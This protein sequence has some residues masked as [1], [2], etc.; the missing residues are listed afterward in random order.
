MRAN[1]KTHL[2]GRSAPEME[3]LRRSW[4]VSRLQGLS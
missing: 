2:P 1:L 4:T 3:P